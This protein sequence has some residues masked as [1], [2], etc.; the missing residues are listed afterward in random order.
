MKVLQLGS[1]SGTTE[2]APELVSGVWGTLE[3]LP[4]L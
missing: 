3:K 4:F 2:V 1:C